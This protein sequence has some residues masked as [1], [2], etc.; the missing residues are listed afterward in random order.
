VDEATLLS[1][2]EE[3]GAFLGI[4]L[5]VRGKRFIDIGLEES[6]LVI[7]RGGGEK[8]EQRVILHLHI[9]LH[10]HC[11]EIKEKRRREKRRYG[12]SM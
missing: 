9:L 2:T 1:A 4:P 3:D 12:K 10:G 5:N 8:S 7:L 6:V 11:P